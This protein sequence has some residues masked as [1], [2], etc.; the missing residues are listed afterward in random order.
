MSD[1]MN[2]SP[3][4]DDI[5]AQAR[6]RVGLKMGFYT[7]AGVYVLVNL[8]LFAI[9]LVSGTGRWHVWPLLGWG[10]GLSIHGLVTFINLRGDGVRERMLK[11]EIERLQRKR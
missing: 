7:H 6:R 3:A 9:S 1:A 5:E 2:D 10:I 4:P 8:G 11:N